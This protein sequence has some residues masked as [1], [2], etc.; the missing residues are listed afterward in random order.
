MLEDSGHNICC[1]GLVLDSTSFSV[2]LKN[3]VWRQSIFFS[4]MEPE[5]L[6]SKLLFE[7]SGHS[8]CCFCSSLNI[9]SNQFDLYCLMSI[10]YFLR[11]GARNSQ[12]RTFARRQ[13]SQYLL[14]LFFTQHLFKSIWSQSIWLVLFAVN[15]FFLEME[16]EVLKS[17]VLLEDSEYNI[18]CF[19][20]ISRKLWLPASLMEQLN[21]SFLLATSSKSVFGW[22]ILSCKSRAFSIISEFEHHFREISLFVKSTILGKSI[23]GGLDGVE[24]WWGKEFIH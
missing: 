14:F 11:N 15:H 10:N 3:N 16:S 8:F 1:S 17:E 12:K 9:F 19:F 18:C 2:N 4:E 21:V 13:W 24:M 5:G 23:F 6:K 20:L 7:D 22:V